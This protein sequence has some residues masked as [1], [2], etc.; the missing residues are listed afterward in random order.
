[1]ENFSL[2]RRLSQFGTLM[3]T[4]FC[5]REAGRDQFGNVYYR[6]RKTPKGVR[7]KRWVMYAGEPEASKVPPEWH[8]WLHHTIDAPL[9]ESSPFH[10]PWQKPY[11]PNATGTN[12]AYFPPGHV[13]AGGKRARTT[14]D[15][16]AWT[17]D[18][19]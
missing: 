16:Q 9:P 13:L 10:K 6:S 17:P 14:G 4:R 18:E 19:S 11:K 15:Y 5:G 12:E 8:I 3:Q 7:E 2:I 1:M